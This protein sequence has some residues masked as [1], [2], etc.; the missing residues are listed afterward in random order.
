MG[1]QVSM[2]LDP[3]VALDVRAFEVAQAELA[4][5]RSLEKQG[6]NMGFFRAP[7]DVPDY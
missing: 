1:G 6:T 7:E 3:V 5:S 4:R 2:H